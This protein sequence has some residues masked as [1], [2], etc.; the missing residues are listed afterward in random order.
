MKRIIGVP[1]AAGMLSLGT[2]ALAAGVHAQTRFEGGP[3]QGAKTLSLSGSVTGG[4]IPAV[5]GLNT[6]AGV[7]ISN[8][9]EAGLAAGLLFKS[10]G[11]SSA[12]G[13][14]GGFV[15]YHVPT[16]SRAIPYL[17]AGLGVVFGRFAGTHR[18]SP[19]VDGTVGEDFFVSPGQ[20]FFLE[21]KLQEPLRGSGTLYNTNFGVRFFFK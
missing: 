5:G 9:T 13:T 11:E 3:Q 18:G 17:G 1:L 4:D 19:L 15:K 10:P 20:S 6:Q 7:Y 16:R 14:V 8:N 12:S 2:L 21:V